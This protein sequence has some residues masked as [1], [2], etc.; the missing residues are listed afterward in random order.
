MQKITTYLVKD[1]L[2]F[3]LRQSRALNVLDSTELLC[4]AIAILLTDRLHLLAGELV[5]D[6]G[7]IA[8]IGLGTDD[9]AGDTGAVVVYFGEPLL[10]DV[11]EG[12]GG[13][14]GEA[15]EENVGL[16]VG[17]RAQAI[18]IFLTGGIEE[19]KGVGFIADP[20]GGSA[21]SLLEDREGLS[22]SWW[23]W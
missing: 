3:V 17:Q 23:W 12:G 1:I 10:A 11:F 5:A 16:G 9:Q 14:H 18:V 7:V 20:G 2:Q 4:H 21:G 6:V 15:D 13:G 19:A 8:Q 22:G